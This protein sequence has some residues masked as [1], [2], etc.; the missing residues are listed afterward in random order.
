MIVS[1]ILAQ[2]AMLCMSAVRKSSDS[3]LLGWGKN[4]ASIFCT[5]PALSQPNRRLLSFQAT[6]IMVMRS[7]QYS[8]AW[9]LC[10]ANVSFLALFGD[11]ISKSLYCKKLV[12]QL[13]Q[14]ISLSRWLYSRYRSAKVW[15][16]S[17]CL[18]AIN[19]SRSTAAVKYWILRYRGTGW[20][21]FKTF[22]SCNSKFWKSVTPAFDLLINASYSSLWKV[23]EIWL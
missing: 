14:A 13:C 2:G 1:V 17:G 23:D 8:A 15:L 4:Q 20:W 10:F 18:L 3:S 21:P 16:V 12:L 19:W 9:K 11:F 7:G 5:A 22:S 6:G